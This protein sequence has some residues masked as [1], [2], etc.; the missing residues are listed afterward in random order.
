MVTGWLVGL[1][2]ALGGSG[3]CRSRVGSAFGEG[4]PSSARRRRSCFG[5][6]AP[7][8]RRARSARVT[9]RCGWGFGARG[10]AGASRSRVR[11]GRWGAGVGGGSGGGPEGAGGVPWMG[12][13]E[14][15]GRR[16]LGVSSTKVG[17]SVSPVWDLCSQLVLC[18]CRV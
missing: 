6:F 13:P 9:R 4:E 17:G 8:G 15:G 3:A 11:G 1:G 2:Q 18:V 16:D 10:G 5:P 12:G 7:F 14:G